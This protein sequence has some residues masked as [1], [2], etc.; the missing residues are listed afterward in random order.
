MTSQNAAAALSAGVVWQRVCA[1]AELPDGAP[2]HAALDGLPICLVRNGDRVHALYD[3]CSHE[4]V[5]LSEGEIDS[6]AIKCWRQGSRFDLTTGQALNPPAS[7][8]VPV[9]PVQ[10]LT[11]VRS[12]SPFTTHANA[13]RFHE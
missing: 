9:Y 6:G 1:L 12:T 5:P 2:V 10:L 3:E 4:N 11:T 8:P 7:T 13:R